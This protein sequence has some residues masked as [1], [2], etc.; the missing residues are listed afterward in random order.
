MVSSAAI[1]RVRH[2]VP[3]LRGLALGVIGVFRVPE[4]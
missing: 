2:W 1:R 4:P 3:G